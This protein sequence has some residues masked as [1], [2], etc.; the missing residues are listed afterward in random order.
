MR[1]PLLLTEA[2]VN[3]L[4]KVMGV[5]V[6]DKENIA[7]TMGMEVHAC[8]FYKIPETPLLLAVGSHQHAVVKHLLERGVDVNE[9]N[10]QGV[11][12]LM[13]CLQNASE[14]TAPIDAAIFK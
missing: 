7:G 9:A 11:N 13:R 12:P 1:T 4:K 14:E 2:R 5:T 8:L 3:A 6:V 10:C